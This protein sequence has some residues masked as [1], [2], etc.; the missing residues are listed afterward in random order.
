MNI[1]QRFPVISSLLFLSGVSLAFR[2]AAANGSS[3]GPSIE[4]FLFLIVIVLLA[5]KIGGELMER[6]NQP[7][8]LGELIAAS[9]WPWWPSWV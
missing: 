8:V 4:G 2:V 5:A 9:T 7:A 6:W 3:E 1:I